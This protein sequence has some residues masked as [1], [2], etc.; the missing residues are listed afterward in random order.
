MLSTF[1]DSHVRSISRRR[2]LLSLAIRSSG[3]LASISLLVAPRVVE[4][5]VE[6]AEE[7]EGADEG[8]Q[9]ASTT[10]EDVP[11]AKQEKR[12]K[13]EK[14]DGRENGS[15]REGSQNEKDHDDDD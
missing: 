8:D 1:A 3:S 9:K 14:S 15:K 4:G 6:G 13:S 7:T 2:F 11:A 12:P 10:G 5:A